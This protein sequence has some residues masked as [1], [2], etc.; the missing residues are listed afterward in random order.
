[1]GMTPDGS[2]QACQSHAEM[3]KRDVRLD[4]SHCEKVADFSGHRSAPMPDGGPPAAGP[5]SAS[6]GK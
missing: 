4:P 6:P 2:K 1:M 5:S 3:V